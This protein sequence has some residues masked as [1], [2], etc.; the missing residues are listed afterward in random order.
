MTD[1]LHKIRQR[2][3]GAIPVVTR[4]EFAAGMLAAMVLVFVAQRAWAQQSAVQA[5]EKLGV[6]EPV[7]DLIAKTI[8]GAVLVACSAI[9][10]VVTFAWKKGSAITKQLQELTVT[11]AGIKQT[12]D[13]MHAEAKERTEQLH[14]LKQVVAGKAE[15]LDALESN[16]TELRRHML[17][18]ATPTPNPSR[19]Q[20]ISAPGALRK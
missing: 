6:L 10:A 7:L 17:D 3:A 12:Q 19:T 8:G 1:M 11:V 16:V 4:M 15:R 5:L 18:H 2:I 20:E 14:E 9:G 13:T